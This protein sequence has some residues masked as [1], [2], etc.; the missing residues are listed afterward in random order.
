M[1]RALRRITLVGLTALVFGLTPNGAWA[2]TPSIDVQ[3]TGSGSGEV[4]GTTFGGADM[5]DPNCLWNGAARSG[6]CDETV[7]S[8]TVVTVTAT[9]LAGSDFVDWGGSCPATPS[10]P[11][12][13]TGS[14]LWGV[15]I[16]V[17][18]R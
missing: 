7:S 10:G 17:Q 16:T 5:F 1:Q 3:P 18:C 11:S 8:T 12:E 15:T 14:R 4:D 13:L 9:P 6:D 2:A